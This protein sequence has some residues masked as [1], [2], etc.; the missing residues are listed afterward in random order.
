MLTVLFSS[1]NGASTL[2]VML[3]ALCQLRVPQGGWKVV[4]VNNASTDETDD[5]LAEFA[6]RLPLTIC[7]QPTPG[8]NRALNTGLKFIEG[9]LVLLTDDDVVPRPDWLCEMRQA[10]DRNPDFDIF[11][12]TIRP[13]WPGQPP[14]WVVRDVLPRQGV[15]GLT[16]ES[17]SDGEASPHNIPGANMAVRSEVFASG[18]RFDE[19]VGPDGSSDYAMGSETA[20]TLRAKAAGHRCFFA[21]RAIVEHIIAPHQLERQWILGR[22]Y[23]LG[24]GQYRALT[25][26]VNPRV[27]MLA[28]YPRYLLGQLARAYIGRLTGWVGGSPDQRFSTAWDINYLR[29]QLTQAKK[30]QQ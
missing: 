28:G 7:R 4:A 26:G 12:G 6:A 3:E 18:L 21:S 16:R 25:S 27:A 29:G 24:R 10:A 8:K 5:I 15:Y 1:F 20:L 13:C 9:D 2:P 19:N 17:L 22:A 14:A 23:R 11:G 30:Q